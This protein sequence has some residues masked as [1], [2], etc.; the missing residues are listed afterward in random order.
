MKKNVQEVNN[1]LA[2][3]KR[4]TPTRD[5]D[6]VR[7]VWAITNHIALHSVK[8]KEQEIE[9]MTDLRQFIDLLNQKYPVISDESIGVDS[10]L[11]PDF[12]Y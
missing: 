4:I 10:C 8:G 7:M 2:N 1:I 12:N 5:Q 9:I 11:N 6:Y 3:I